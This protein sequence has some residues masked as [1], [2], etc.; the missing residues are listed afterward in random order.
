MKVTFL[1]TGTS[2]GVPV[3]GCD[4]VVCSSLDFRDKRLRSSIHLEIEGKS[5]VIDT[6]PDFRMQMLREKINHVDAVIFTHEH[7]DHTAGLDDIRPYNFMQK[8][9]MPVFATKKVLSQ[10]K[11]EFAYIF[12]EVKYPG[13]PKVLTHEI[14]KANPFEVEGIPITPIEVMHY[15]LP[16]LGFRTGDFTY[17]TDAKT[18][19]KEELEKIKGTKIL[20]LNALQASHHISHFTL[21]EAIEMVNFLKPEKAFFTHISHK[22]GAHGEVEANL[23]AHIKLAYDGL[24]VDIA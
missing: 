1:G 23:P 2:Q 15:R 14:S 19:A 6:G 16:V 22:L 12:E 17:I 5:L 13:V 24:K 20:V 3:I 18:I 7:K 11:R 21:E 8:K 10:I 9:D 4:C